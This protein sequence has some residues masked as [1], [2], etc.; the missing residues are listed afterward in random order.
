MTRRRNGGGRGKAD[1]KAIIAGW[2]A[3]RVI[4]APRKRY[5]YLYPGDQRRCRHQNQDQ[6]PSNA[7]RFSLAWHQLSNQRI[8]IKMNE[9]RH[10]L[11]VLVLQSI[12]PSNE[13][14]NPTNYT[15]YTN[16]SKSYKLPP[17]SDLLPPQCVRMHHNSSNKHQCFSDSPS[18]HHSFSFLAIAKA[19]IIHIHFNPSPPLRVDY[20]PTVY[21]PAD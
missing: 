10:P 17:S 2:E 21:L 18:P 1:K 13:Y 11:P 14:R 3:A 15:N 12:H 20:N 9:Q 8:S 6:H 16:N 5:Y 7:L 19:T 4:F